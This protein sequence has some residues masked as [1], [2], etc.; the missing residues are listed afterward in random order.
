M[1]VACFHGCLQGE[2]HKTF[3]PERAE[4]VR[5][6]A[7][8]GCTI[9]PVSTVGEDDLFNVRILWPDMITQINK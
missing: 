7:R 8:F 4:F 5:M 6:A 2:A 9:V 3:W 1:L